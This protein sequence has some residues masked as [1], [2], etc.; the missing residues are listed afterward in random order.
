[1]WDLER[2]LAVARFTGAWSAAIWSQG[3]QLR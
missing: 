2:H 1:L 3:S